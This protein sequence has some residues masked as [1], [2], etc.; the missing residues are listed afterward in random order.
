MNCE[1]TFNSQKKSTNQIWQAAK[2]SIYFPLIPTSFCLFSLDYPFYIFLSSPPFS[3]LFTPDPPPKALRDPHDNRDS[4]N[5][6]IYVTIKSYSFTLL[7][8][9]IQCFVKQRV[10]R[11]K[12]GREVRWGRGRR[13]KMRGGCG[14]NQDTGGGKQERKRKGK[15]HV[16]QRFVL[17]WE[18]LVEQ[19]AM[20]SG[21]VC[22]NEQLIKLI[23]YPKHSTQLKIN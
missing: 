7:S 18:K 22:C 4:R 3:F 14:F 11:E 16:R 17:F 1:W 2:S 23:N 9:S 20:G 6:M 5:S 8:P 12:E 15:S 13:V 19:T 10:K 21:R